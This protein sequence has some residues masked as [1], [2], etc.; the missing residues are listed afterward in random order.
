VK[1]INPLPEFFESKAS[2]QRRLSRPQ[3]VDRYSEQL[4]ELFLVRNPKLRAAPDTIPTAWA[5]FQMQTP[6]R[7]KQG[8]WCYFSWNHSLVHILPKNEFL[9]LSASRN[10]NLI[11][12]DEQQILRKF[13]IGI[14]GL[15]VGNSIA[16]CL[17]MEGIGHKM[18]LADLDD[19]AFSNLNRLR[20]SLTVLGMNKAAIAARQIYEINPYADLTIADKGLRE[21]NLNSFF[22]SPKI[23]LFVDEMDDV[24]MKIKL[25]LAAKQFKIPVVSAVDNGDYSIL[26]VERFDQTPNRPIYHGKFKRLNIE[27]LDHFNFGQ[28]L[29]MIN[30]MVG[31]DLV[32]SRMKQSLLEVGNT[33]Y[34]WPQLA[35]A[36]MLNASIVTYVIKRIALGMSVKSGKYE[37]N[38]DRVFDASYDRPNKKQK[39]QRETK[40][41]LDM[42]NKLF[43]K[44]Q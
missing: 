42:Q 5:K 34:S 2:A 4:H 23:D 3:I 1:T 41:F 10:R 21:N 24:K 27:K 33:L 13:T 19:L 43:L 15:S 29:K 38:F 6:K 32:T 31:I 25:R 39:R 12:S 44:K 28:K 14:A 30:E 40:Q 37:V 18:K 9:E 17:A 36:A 16:V 8:I 7:L 20:S 35:G 22:Q 26:D 11:N